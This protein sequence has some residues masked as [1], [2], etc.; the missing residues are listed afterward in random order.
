MTGI[1]EITGRAGTRAVALSAY[2]D[3]RTE[4]RA[5]CRAREWIKALR[6]I[7]I[8]GLPMR[9]RFTIG[10]DS[11]W[12]FTELYLHKEQAILTLM[13]TIA[14]VDAL[15]EREQPSSVAW[16]SGDAVTQWVAKARGALTIPALV[17]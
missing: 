2:L 4:E 12:W 15:V 6:A 3:P 16:R 7:R 10:D 9:S 5:Q 1:V 14:A 8:D 13:R 17:A 11:L